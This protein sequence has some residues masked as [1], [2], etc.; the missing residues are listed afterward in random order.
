M[1]S[2]QGSR[3]PGALGGFAGQCETLLCRSG[4]DRALRWKAE[5]PGAKVCT[6]PRGPAGRTAGSSGVQAAPPCAL[7][8]V[9][10][11]LP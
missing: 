11:G 6:R 1:T 8:H 9:A 7:S 4:P 2:K 3:Q 5:S 10:G